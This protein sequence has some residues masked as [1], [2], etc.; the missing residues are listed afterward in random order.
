[1]S[2]LLQS[3]TDLT[4]KDQKLLK[5]LRWG[6]VIVSLIFVFHA[7]PR[8]K[9]PE[10][11]PIT[12]WAMFSGTRNYKLDA[13][14]HYEVHVEDINGESYLFDYSENANSSTGTIYRTSGASQHDDVGFS[15]LE[16]L[17]TTDDASTWET[18]RLALIDRIEQ[19]YEIEVSEAELW[20]VTY[21]VDMNEFPYVDYDNPSENTYLSDLTTSL[22][23]ES[24]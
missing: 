6:I 20:R 13:G 24:E 14:T 3:S 23:R 4:A 15:I 8:H 10:V 16:V 5:K 11:Y 17:A 1:M 21:P 18:Y 9:L 2:S 12:R 19:H 22:N 7:I